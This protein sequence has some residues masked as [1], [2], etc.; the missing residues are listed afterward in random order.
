MPTPEEI[1]KKVTLMAVRMA[2]TDIFNEQL[3]AWMKIHD[4]EALK[5][6]TAEVRA[7]ALEGRLEFQK[8]IG[9]IVREFGV[10]NLL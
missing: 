5:S 3:G 1:A 8:R 9:A 10:D 4:P 6:I 7:T 2:T